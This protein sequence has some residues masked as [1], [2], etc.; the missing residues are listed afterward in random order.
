MKIRNQLMLWYMVILLAGLFL[1]GGW[2]YY[3]MV[4]EHPAITK[5]L[6]RVAFCRSL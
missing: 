2:A 1:I 5:A 6:A 4:V 3:E